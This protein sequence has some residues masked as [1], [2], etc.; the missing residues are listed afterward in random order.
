MRE[1]IELLFDT[2]MQDISRAADLKNELDRWG[3]FSEYEDR[4]LDLFGER[5]L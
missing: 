1:R 3:L 5:N 4:F 2:A